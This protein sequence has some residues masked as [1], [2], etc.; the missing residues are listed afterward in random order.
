MLSKHTQHLATSIPQGCCYD[1]R[2]IPTLQVD[3]ASLSISAD[4][5]D[6]FLI[7]G[8]ISIMSSPAQRPRGPW[9]VS[10]IT[11]GSVKENNIFCQS[12]IGFAVCRKPFFISITSLVP[13]WLSSSTSYSLP[14]LFSSSVIWENSAFPRCSFHSCSFHSNA[15]R[16][17]PHGCF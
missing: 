8:S 2:A 11:S 14:T 5:W 7:I 4:A 15:Q 16:E 17:E 9:G 6:Y 1:V 12:D 10:G 3:P 13:L